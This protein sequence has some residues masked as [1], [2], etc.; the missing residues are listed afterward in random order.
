[1]KKLL[2]VLVVGL[3]IGSAAMADCSL[4]DFLPDDMGRDPA[5]AFIFTTVATSSSSTYGSANSSGTS[6]CNG[7]NDIE[8]SPDIK[9]NEF[10]T[11][12][13]DDLS[14]DIAQGGGPHLQSLS[15]LLGCPDSDYP[16]LAELA[17]RNYARLFPST[18]EFEAEVFL[19]RLKEVISNDP[20][21]SE[22]CVHIF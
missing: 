15:S 22:N 10:V 20:Q 13:M 14:E 8:S 7:E 11:W 2:V 17:R 16:A 18:E 3:L 9:Q 6:G 5:G 19:A 21:L 12:N 4:R 1:M